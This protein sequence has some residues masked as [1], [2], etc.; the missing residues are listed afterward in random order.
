MRFVGKSKRSSY[1]ITNLP[2]FRPQPASGLLEGPGGT[3]HRQGP[4]GIDIEV[5]RNRWSQKNFNLGRPLTALRLLEGF[6]G[7]GHRQGPSGIDAEIKKNCFSQ[8]K[9]LALVGL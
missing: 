3:G 2:K 4:S 6:E 8:K 1:N 9:I 5:N 7:A